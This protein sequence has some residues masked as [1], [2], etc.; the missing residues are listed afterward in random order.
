[1][2]NQTLLAAALVVTGLSFLPEKRSTSA[3]TPEAT[4]KQYCAGCHG[5]QVEMFVDRQWK[6][7]NTKTELVASISKGHPD[8]GM[9]A[10]EAALKPAEISALADY[11]TAALAKGEKFRVDAAPQS[12][13]FASSAGLTVRL[14]T[15]V[16][17]LGVPWGLAFLPGGDLLVTERAGSIWR[18]AKNGTKTQVSGGPTVLAEGQG[19]LLDVEVHPQ[20]AQ[21]NWVYFSYSAVK[22]GPD[23]KLSTTAIMRAK[24]DGDRLTDQKVLFEAQPWAKTRHHY[25][26][27]LVFDRAGLLYF[28]VGDRGSEKTNPQSL[29]SDA[30]KV[31]RLKDDGGIPADNPFANSAHPTIFSYGHRN[32][33]GMTLNAATGELWE[34]EHG[35]RG[36]DE[37]NIIRKG[38]NYGWPVISY[39]INYDG[40]PITNLTAKEGMAQPQHYWIPSIG[41]SGMAFVPTGGRYPAW[42]GN[43]LIGSLRFKYLNRCEMKA[44]KIVKEE[45]VYPNIGRVRNVDI[46]PDGYAYISVEDPGYVFR[47]VPV[48]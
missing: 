16:R 28:T 44:G 10:W 36:G 26:S 24:L 21:N 29:D 6:F 22:D 43:A 8:L 30:G 23:G 12:P 11:I 40:K 18:V 17:G 7:G 48:K 27:R 20:F 5:E 25:G 3:A 32:P 13:T 47:L 35:P 42:G 9:P 41:P 1:M 46:G 2:L 4:Y 19:G 34:N 38:Q 37:A 45:I 31:H 39:G 33:Q 14:D 15:V